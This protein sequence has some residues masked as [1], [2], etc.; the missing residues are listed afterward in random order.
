MDLLLVGTFARLNRQIVIERL[1]LFREAKVL[2]K[3]L[4]NIDISINYDSPLLVKFV[5]TIADIIHEKSISRLMEGL[6]TPV[7][8]EPLNR[9]LSAQ[10]AIL[11]GRVPVWQGIRTIKSRVERCS[12]LIGIYFQYSRQRL[13]E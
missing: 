10:L 8:E 13:D 6:A 4:V 7:R 3:K 2:I 5:F 1:R 11:H 9:I 12:Y